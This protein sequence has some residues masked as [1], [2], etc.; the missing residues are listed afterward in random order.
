[1]PD[2]ASFALPAN[3]AGTPLHFV[4]IAGAGMAPLARI[5]LEL[6]FP[7]SGSDLI[8]HARC[9]PLRRA[10][11]KIAV[12]H[13]PENLPGDAAIV[14]YSS[15]AGADNPELQAAHRRGLPCFR[16]GEFLS[17][18]ARQCRRTVAVAGA[19]GKS[20]VTALL[21]WIL[22]HC[23][24]PAGYMIGAEVNGDFPNA[25][26]G[27][28]DIFV[29][30]ADES[31]GTF[32]LLQG[33]LAVI[34]NIDDDHAWTAAAR[35]KLLE[36]FAAFAA[37]FRRV[38]SGP[39]AQ[40]RKVLAAL[41]NAAP[42]PPESAAAIDAALPA[43]MLGFE[44]ANAVLAVLAA[45]HLGAARRDAVRA[46]ADFPGVAR[47]MT[48]RGA[49]PD[50]RIVLVEDYAHHPAELEASFQVLGQRWPGRRQVVIFQ[51]HRYQRLERYFDRFVRLLAAVPGQVYLAPVFAAWSE[52]GE[53]DSAML[54]EAV[55]RAGGR[56]EAVTAEWAR[57]AEQVGRAA[58]NGGGETVIAVIGAGDLNAVL[59]FLREKLKKNGSGDCQN[60][61][62]PV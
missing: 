6:G 26:A 8:D 51:P 44:R 36:E 45:E 53:Y 13:A 5:A 25:S 46:L 62:N 17:V 60:G 21:S 9:H 58:G 31:D 7:V 37:R 14:I 43:A 33:E 29:T 20:S 41:P 16:R 34:P 47:R 39:D 49:S 22:R 15:A 12:G 57:L 48:V 10:G 50:G 23:G 52:R 35:A 18:L 2:A 59:P 32:A 54:A 27:D 42:V 30:E 1:M 4:G 19:H 56:A 61:Q 24:I 28:G 11:A 55:N 3:R 40:T 38:I